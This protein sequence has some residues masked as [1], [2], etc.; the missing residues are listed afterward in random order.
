[1]SRNVD[2]SVKFD[3]KIDTQEFKSDVDKLKKYSK[4]AFASIG[5][6]A[7]GVAV[8]A[9]TVGI[10]FESAFAGVKKTVNAT[11]A[12]L[13]DLKQ[14]IRDMAKEIPIAANEI[15]GIAEAAGQLG[16][17]TR[18]IEGFTRVMADLGVATNLTGEEAASTLAKFANI[19]QMPQE[20]FANLGSTIVALGN[21]LATTEADIAAMSLRLAGAG[22]QIGLTEAQILSFSGALSSVGIEAEA[23]G[24][25]FS[26]LMTDMQLAVETNSS[27]LSKYASVAGMTGEQFKVAFKDNA[28]N[29]IIEFIKGLNNTERNGKSATA[30]LSDMGITEIRLSDA[31]KRAAGA[32]DVFADAIELGNKAWEENNALTKEAEQRY[33][34]TESKLKILGNKAKD[35]GITAWDAFSGSFGEAVDFASEKVEDLSA[36]LE[37]GKLSGAVENVGELFGSVVEA[38]VTLADVALPPLVSILGF[39]G[40]NFG[41]IAGVTGTATAAIVAYKGATAA[42]NVVTTTATTIGAARAAGVSV[43]NI[44]TS[45]LN[46]NLFKE[47]T[48]TAAKTVT[49]G[50][51]TVGTQAHTAAQVALNTAMSANPVGLVIAGLTALVGVVAGVTIAVNKATE[52]YYNMGDSLDGY[53]EKLHEVKNNADLTEDYAAKWRTLNTEIASGTLSA[54]ALAQKEAE[55]KECEQWF[56]DN[57]G[58]WIDA[59]AKKNGIRQETVDLITEK[60]A[61]EKE[62]AYIEAKNTALDLADE[63]PK[64]AK[65]VAKWQEKND[66]LQS[67]NDELGKQNIILKKATLGWDELTDT[68]KQ[69][70]IDDVN[71]SL[72]T[73]YTCFLDLDEAITQNTSAIDK[74]TKKIDKNQKKIDDSTD[75]LDNYK[76]TVS[77]LIEYDLG[78]PLEKFAQK[79]NLINK[80]QKEFNETGAISAETMKQ[81]SEV[82]PEIAKQIEESKSP[83]ETLKTIFADLDTKLI[84]AKETAQDFGAELKNLPKELRINVKFKTPDGKAYARG[85]KGASEGPAIVNDG[86]GPELIQS[87]D[88]AFRMVQS[89]G[90]V[91]TWL[92]S[93]DRVYTAEQTRSMLRNVPRYANGIGNKTFGA[94]TSFAHIKDVTELFDIAGTALAATAVDSLSESFTK[95][96]KE[97]AES[98]TKKFDKAVESLDLK[99]DFG[100]ISETEYYNE[101]VKLRDQYLTEGTKEWQA[102]TEEIYTYQRKTEESFLEWKFDQGIITEREYYQK[103]EEYRDKYF[104][105]GS[106]DW[107]DYTDK[108]FKYYKDQATSAIDAIGE[109]QEDLIDTFN[110]HGKLTRTVTVEGWNEDGSALIWNELNTSTKELDEVTEYVDKLNAAEQRM[111]DNGFD[112]DFVN[113]YMAKIREMSVEEGLEYVRLLANANDDTFKR[114]INIEYEK[115]ETYKKLATS[116]LDD[117]ITDNAAEFKDAYISALEAAGF[118]VPEGFFDIGK[119]SAESFEQG[120]SE[121]LASLFNPIKETMMALMPGLSFEGAG[122]AAV[123]R[124]FAPVYNFYSSNDTTTEQIWAAQNASERDK[125]S[126][127]Y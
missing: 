125:L 36:A 94:R 54:D 108:I 67:T 109:M 72:G 3:T 18:N 89:D 58:D 29:A 10:S 104:V 100:A 51:A 95:G 27:A 85:T 44:A 82:S 12:E 118:E 74:N 93:G 66:V 123:N 91:L 30:V 33:A 76:S 46:G 115:E 38:A 70:R 32:S 6:A 122:L 19:T 48:L 34:T 127:G 40:E 31:L 87:K 126:G 119:N 47:N 97:N 42:A 78:E 81:I 20:K 59:E 14:G 11:E 35:L 111:L 90:A 43:L 63:I 16:I 110:D 113:K 4:K 64:L 84:A 106:E 73:E 55:L 37:D 39:V 107:Q 22:S 26:R 86:N 71:Q 99:L 8:G 53:S 49:E 17:E 52:S 23:G 112:E 62:S 79:Y 2:G 69:K 120:F 75:S 9:A 57:H 83:G 101:L 117:E 13:N 116:A 68:E 80:A 1:M 15:A 121:Q 21:N 45:L 105:K 25:A 41:L 102:C 7:A 56:I 88:G 50:A 24:S 98:M 60:V 5:V 65:D 96:L 92:N 114:H 61:L 77:S 28:A 124:T 103:L